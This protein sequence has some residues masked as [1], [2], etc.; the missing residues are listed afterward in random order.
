M[1]GARESVARSPAHAHTA[2]SRSH[3]TPKLPPQPI[4][5][6]SVPT[7]PTLPT[8]TLIHIQLLDSPLVKE[9][10]P[11][12]RISNHHSID[13]SICRSLV[14]NHHQ[15]ADGLTEEQQDEY[16]EA[17]GLYDKSGGGALNARQLGFVMRYLG[18][19]PTDPEL[20]DMIGKYGSGTHSVPLIEDRRDIN[21]IQYH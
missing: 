2:R 5:P 15:Q 20:N 13:L 4:E 1:G 17:W 10:N 6:W 14:P 8:L 18:Q 3:Q 21:I 9:S 19:N 12:I 11:Y 7:L 16:R